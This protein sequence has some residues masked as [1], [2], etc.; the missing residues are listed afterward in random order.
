M[1]KKYY[2]SHDINAIQD[3]KIQYLLAKFGGVAYALWWRVIEML[4][5]AEENKLPH[6]EYYYLALENQLKVDK[7]IVKDFIR[8]CID[9]VELFRCDGN[10]FWSER[11]Y[12]NV[13]KMNETKQKQ[14]EAGKISASKR[15]QTSTDVEQVLNSTST[16]VQVNSTNRNINRNNIYTPSLI[17]VTDFFI[18]NGYSGKAGEQAFDYYEQGGWVDSKGSKVKNWKQKMRG[19]WF[20][21]EHKINKQT[22]ANFSMPIN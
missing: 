17:E 4:H 5:E 22:I 6:K 1:N 14:S 15:K 13:N 7:D 21:D 19:V 16:S 12:E 18:E 2:F 20:R 3:V 10:Y 11:V 8:C 9:E